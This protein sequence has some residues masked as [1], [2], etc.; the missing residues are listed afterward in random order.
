MDNRGN[1]FKV[2]ISKPACGDGIVDNGID[3]F[4]NYTEECDVGDNVYDQA[5][6]TYGLNPA[7]IKSGCNKT[8][9]QYTEPDRTYT[10][11]EDNFYYVNETHLYIL[12]ST[13]RH[14]PSLYLPP[15]I[16]P[17]YNYF[18]GKHIC[19][20]GL[21][22]LDC[23]S[24]KFPGYPLQNL[25][26]FTDFTPHMALPAIGRGR[27]RALSYDDEVFGFSYVYNSAEIIVQG[28]NKVTIDHDKHP[29]MR[30]TFGRHF[31]ASKATTSLMFYEIQKSGDTYSIQQK[32]FGPTDMR[33]L[34]PQLGAEFYI[35]WPGPNY[36]LSRLYNGR[37]FEI[38][39]FN[40]ETYSSFASSSGI[41]EELLIKHSHIPNFEVVGDIVFYPSFF[42]DNMYLPLV[43]RRFDA[44][45]TAS[46]S[47]NV[48]TTEKVPWEI[49]LDEVVD[50]SHPITSIASF[51]EGVIVSMKHAT[52]IFFDVTLK[53]L[54]SA[55][56]KGSTPACDLGEWK[57]IQSR[58][59]PEHPENSPPV[60]AF[61]NRYEI[62]NVSYVG[63]N[64]VID[65]PNKIVLPPDNVLPEKGLAR[66]NL[67]YPYDLNGPFLIN[68]GVYK[69]SME[70][71]YGNEI[72]NTLA[73]S[74]LNLN[75]GE[76]SHIVIDIIGPLL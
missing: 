5:T 22:C 76:S 29:A 42:N 27:L 37:N 16:G 67:E 12:R 66:F 47:V 51:E 8:T 4:A 74:H 40:K 30:E 56:F 1:T 3:F 13:T 31:I 48:Y 64:L 72:W 28:N 39:P 35:W 73:L 54:I 46:Y 53:I 38:I 25:N 19:Y 18:A 24:P 44:A 45:N 33:T 71:G 23:L 20:G 10:Y 59:S 52:E 34:P 6:E 57:F 68:F 58:P 61:C 69:N 41:D 21:F 32:S 75:T 60:Y 14:C 26:N 15:E 55:D 11:D 70:T 7:W 43:L 17:K 65:V 50:V 63:G 62:Y 9:C 2:R 36:L 49:T